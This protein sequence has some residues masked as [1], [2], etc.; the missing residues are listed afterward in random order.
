MN[1]DLRS[2]ALAVVI[3]HPEEPVPSLSREASFATALRSTLWP[4]A[5]RN[6]VTRPKAFALRP[7][8]SGR[9]VGRRAGA[10]SGGARN[11]HCVFFVQ[12][13]PSALLAFAPVG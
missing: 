11:L 13:D 10:S 8:A 7:I 6:F 5:L 12:A 4:R 3:C 9:R 1:V 2:R